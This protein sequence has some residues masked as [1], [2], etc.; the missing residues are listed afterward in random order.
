MRTMCKAKHVYF[1]AKFFQVQL[2]G[3]TSFPFMASIFFHTLAFLLRRRLFLPLSDICFSEALFFK[4]F[5][6]SQMKET[7]EG[8]DTDLFT[9]KFTHTIRVY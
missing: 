6:N 3:F 9:K 8:E 2:S 5:C 4:L 1:L 7:T